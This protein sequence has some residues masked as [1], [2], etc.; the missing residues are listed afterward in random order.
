MASKW[1]LNPRNGEIGCFCTCGEIAFVKDISSNPRPENPTPCFT[2]YL[3][4]CELRKNQI[5]EGTVE[6]EN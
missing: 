4:I 5:F 6:D 2:H 3:E 1:S